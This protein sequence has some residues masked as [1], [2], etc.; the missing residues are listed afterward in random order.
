VRCNHSQKALCFLAFEILRVELKLKENFESVELKITG[1]LGKEEFIELS[2]STDPKIIV[3]AAKWCGYCARFLGETKEFKSSND[4]ELCLV[5]ADDPDESL[6]DTLKL[7]L[8]PTI[9]VFQSGKQLFRQDG[10]PGVGLRSSDL[11]EA[12]AFSLTLK[13]PRIE[14]QDEKEN[15]R[16][17]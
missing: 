4:V 8:V 15:S 6:W 3:L 11:R 9:V 16:G 17:E 10:L 5:D 14:T 13:Q 1:W 7:K 12:L 2:N